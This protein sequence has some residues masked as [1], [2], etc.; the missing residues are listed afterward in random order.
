MNEKHEMKPT[1]VFCTCCVLRFRSR[2]LFRVKKDLVVTW[3]TKF[4]ER[5]NENQEK[6]GVLT[7]MF[8]LREVGLLLGGCQGSVVYP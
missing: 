5:K 8:K 6:S 2:G 3:C 4:E 7:C 1:N